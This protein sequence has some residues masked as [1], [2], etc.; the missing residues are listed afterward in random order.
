VPGVVA[1]VISLGLLTSGCS[2]S[3]QLDSMFA[4]PKN[5]GEVEYTGSL[6]PA[7]PHGAA[8]LAAKSPEESDLAMA[9]AAAREL[10]TRGGKDSSVP[11]ENPA[12]GARGTVTPISATYSQDGTTCHDFLASY[13]RNGTESWLHGEACRSS[14]KWEVRSMKPWRRT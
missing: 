1:L 3:Y 6:R 7:L 2:F 11:W 14:G 5:D 13:V 9:R 4:K 10:L 12:T 8:A